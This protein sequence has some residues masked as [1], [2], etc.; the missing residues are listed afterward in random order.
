MQY[1][2]GNRL[3]DLPKVARQAY[4]NNVDTDQMLQYAVSDQGLHRFLL[5][6]DFLDTSTASHMDYDK[7]LRFQNTKGKYGSV[8]SKSENY[9]SSCFCISNFKI[10][11]ICS[12]HQLGLQSLGHF[13]FP[14]SVL[15]FVHLCLSLSL[16]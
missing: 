1:F 5:I 7:K 9:Y 12:G 16:K 2:E 3:L 4:A 8:Y 15:Y 13:F 10:S 11:I 14:I 6:Q